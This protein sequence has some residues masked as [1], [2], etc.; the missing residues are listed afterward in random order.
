MFEQWLNDPI[1]T[2]LI[3]AALLVFVAL[4]IRYR[5]RVGALSNQLLLAFLGVAAISLA[6]VVGVVIW[7]T[8]AILT[9]QTGE[10]FIA[11]AQS[12]SQRLEEGLVKEVELLQNLAKQATFF[13]RIFGAGSVAL[14]EL[15]PEQRQE[16]VQ[17]REENWNSLAGEPVRAQIR[18]NPVSSDLNRF[19]SDFP[20]HSQV[21]F[22]NEY[23]VLE[24]VG[25][26]MPE[27]YYFGNEEWW[28]QAWNNGQGQIYL[29]N[30]RIVPGRLEATIDIVVPV[31]QPDADF[32]RGL[33]RSRFKISS[34]SAL[35]NTPPVGNT[36]EFLLVNN[37]GLIIHSPKQ[38]QIG[39]QI[40]PAIAHHVRQ[41]PVAWSV[42]TG[43]DSAPI[44]H[45]HAA[46]LPAAENNYLSNLGW[47]LI[48]QQPASEALTTAGQISTWVLGVGLL[49]LVLAAVVGL[50]IARRLTRPLEELTHS[51][52]AIAQGQLDESVKLSGPVEIRLLA[53][54]FNS[55]AEQL[56]QT[57]TSLENRVIARTRRLEL[58]ANLGERLNAILDIDE[59]LKQVVAQLNEQFHYYH[60]HIYLVDEEQDKLVMAAG[61]GR[62][63]EEM[64]AQGHNIPLNAVTS[65]VA[66]AARLGQVVKVDNVRESD[67]WLPNPLLPDT[68]SEM[69]VPI[70]LE[71][72]VV[73]VLDVQENKVAGL[74]KADENL[75]RSLANQVAIA[76]RNARLFKQVQS[77]LEEAHKLQRRY[78]EQQWDKERVVRRGARRVKFSLGEST[79]LNETVITRVRQQA[80]SL[81]KPAI[82]AYGSQ[83]NDNSQA[84]EEQPSAGQHALVAP[85]MLR[86]V[87]IGDVQLH[88]V[89]PNRV[90]SEG[91]LALITA[92]IDQV[93][94]T[95]ENLRLIDEAQ[96]RASREQLLGQIS[97]RLRRA[98][99]VETLM[100]VG[101]EELSKILRPARTFV[102]FGPKEELK[103]QITNFK[104]SGQDALPRPT[105]AANVKPDNS[106]NGHGEERY[107]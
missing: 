53:Q 39:A 87:P 8:Q 18:V 21:I 71:D 99:D 34:L 14:D 81:K 19:V 97:D 57:L 100:K 24:G 89:D 54:T 47:T 90:W 41:S 70:V 27:Y 61:T 80:F 72:K 49:A 77:Q 42:N 69:A 76:L 46:L 23:G 36:G 48:V 28:Q 74:D 107:E 75:L 38:N 40:A 98:P 32:A 85:I 82:V 94:Q 60:A 102:Q 20:A 56:S 83:P 96:E 12:N 4:V 88:N 43:P 10:V 33:L 95:A 3:V 9:N 91:E 16:M 67:D 58:I 73:G 62:A 31:R 7:Q 17:S 30:L 26:D 68:Y 105:L 45:S 22:V 51:A 106:Q 15:A 64:L 65:L 92:V 37:D 11:L 79:T 66:R 13:Y 63:G 84:E 101:V 103:E 6:L 86:N 5:R 52:A 55:M 1:Q 93:A 29:G 25:G 2:L 78:I 44:I 104:E 35:V 59:L 50:V